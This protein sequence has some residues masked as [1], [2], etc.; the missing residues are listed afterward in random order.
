MADVPTAGSPQQVSAQGRAQLEHSLGDYVDGGQSR[1]FTATEGRAFAEA[2]LQRLGLTGFEVVVEDQSPPQGGCTLMFLGEG[3][4]VEV[5]GLLADQPP[6]DSN[7]TVVARQ[8]RDQVADECLSLPEAARVTETI[9]G[10][11]HRWPTSSV[12]DPAATCTTVDLVAGGSTQVFL[13]GP[14]RTTS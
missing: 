2:E 10:A 13:I 12:V 7:V 6:A 4:T 9:L 1:C 14:E 11:E 5:R 3:A 8:L